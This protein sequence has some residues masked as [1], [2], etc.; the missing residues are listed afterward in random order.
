MRLSLRT[1][2]LI[3]MAA[4]FAVLGA[5]VGFASLRF[6]SLGSAIERILQENYRSVTAV[7]DMKEALE[8][9]ESSRD[10]ARFRARFERAL[11]VERHN[12]TEP[13]EADLVRDLVAAYDAY[14]AAP[15]PAR[16]ERVKEILDE[17]LDMNHRAMLAADRRAREA[18]ERSMWITGAFG[19]AILAA[20][21]I[22]SRWLLRTVLGPVQELTASVQ[23]IAKGDLDQVVA[24]PRHEELRALAEAFNAMAKSLRAFKKSSLGDLIQA[25]EAAQAAV[26]SLADPVLL[27]DTGGRMKIQNLAAREAL[28]GDSPPD[29][30]KRALDHVLASG[31]PYSV[32]GYDH[33][34]RLRRGPLER[35]YL[36]R[37]TPMRDD[38][39]DLLG[40][41][42]LLQDVTRLKQLDELKTDVVATVAHE[43]RTPLTALR[44]N[45]HL[46]L[47]GLAGALTPKQEELLVASREECERLDQL[48][49]SILDV[50]RIES[51]ALRMKKRPVAPIEAAGAA[52]DA[53][54]A[55]AEARGVKLESAVDAGL[56][57]IQ[58]DPDRL[59]LVFANLVSNAIRYTPAGGEI[60]V[61]AEARDERVRFTVADTGCGIAAEHLPHIFEKYYRRG[62]VKE[63]EGESRGAGLGLTIAREVVLAHAGEIG[64][65]SR[66]GEGTRFWFEVP[67]VKEA[68]TT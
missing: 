11:D 56:P 30:V 36:P 8:R 34:V 21:A 67:T 47:E 39:G 7:E 66:P 38:S 45:T 44:M 15:D 55:D 63:V 32:Q 51:G 14:S 62:A 13:G 53:F 31:A 3:A 4:L 5:F 9:Q 58:A 28:D 64:V 12:I 52:V 43:I 26:D 10:A 27:F 42:I 17:V 29:E 6:R 59:K 19:A 41:T 48:A 16:F 25:R 65:E 40:A 18:A 22:F 23:A 54:R 68:A 35:L 37:G 33:M 49:T 1:K 20:G 57:L 50:A 24:P 2:L 46:L 61:S 60:R